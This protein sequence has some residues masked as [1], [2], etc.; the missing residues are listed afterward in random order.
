[1][2]IKPARGFTGNHIV[3]VRD[4]IAFDYHGYSRWKGLLEHTRAKAN[5]RWPGW[6]AN[7][8]QLTKDVLISEAKSREIEGRPVQ[9]VRFSHPHLSIHRGALQIGRPFRAPFDI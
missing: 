1:M 2:W 8:V 5:R 3:A 9:I 7:L 4:D 6:S